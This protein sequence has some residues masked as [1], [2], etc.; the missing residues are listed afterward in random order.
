VELSC[1]KDSMDVKLNTDDP[2]RGKLYTQSFPAECQVRGNKTKHTTI[3][4]KFNDPECG[5]VDEGEGVYS[6][7]LVVQHHP[8]IQR[9]G[10]KAIKLMC[11]FQTENQTVTNGYRFDVDRENVN[12]GVATAIVNATAP[13]PR[14]RLRIVDRNGIDIN[15]ASIGEELYLRLDL[16]ANS[17]Y[18]IFARNLVAKSGDNSDTVVLLDDR[19]CPVDRSIFP[20]LSV[21]PGSKSL[22]GRFEAFKFSEDQVVRFQVNVQFCLEECPPARCGN[23]ISYGRRKRREVNEGTL[24]TVAGEVSLDGPVTPEDELIYHEM[25][26]QKEIIVDSSSIK[27]LRTGYLPE[28]R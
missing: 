13:S 12:G 7:V 15:G 21:V 20:K 5:V 6:N 11:L 4:I 18:G 22:E 23:I 2:F 25:P 16:D 26:L 19:G 8:V 1:T 9:K 14:I 3:T 10:D 17:V 27:P 28:E 24:L